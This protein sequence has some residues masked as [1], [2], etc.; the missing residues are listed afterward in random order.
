[1]SKKEQDNKQL[2]PKKGLMVRFFR[3]F[4]LALIG[5]LL[6]LVIGY[7][8]LQSVWV[9]NK[10][11]PYATQYISEELGAQ[12]HL[13]R[14]DLSL[15]D[16][17]D[18]EGLVVLDQKQDTLLAAERFKT[19]L[20]GNLL[21]LL[22][23]RLEIDQIA[24]QGVKCHV[25]RK[26]G[27]QH[28]N[29]QFLIDYFK[30][31]SKKPKKAKSPFLLSIKNL[32]LRDVAFEYLDEVNGVEV[33]SKLID[34]E[35]KLNQYDHVGSLLDI[36]YIQS[37][38]LT[39][40]LKEIEKHPLE[41][42]PIDPSTVDTSVVSSLD[43]VP[44]QFLVGELSLENNQFYY[45]H[46]R[47]QAEYDQNKPNIN[48]NHI[49][50][51]RSDIYLRKITGNSADGLKCI[52]TQI[53]V[54]ERS[55]FVISEMSADTLRLSTRQIALE[56]M[57]LITPHSHI[58]AD[59]SLRFDGFSAFNRFED[60]VSLGLKLKL[61]NNLS[62][63]DIT[64]FSSALAKNAFFTKN[65]EKLV[66]IEGN[67]KGKLNRLRGDE[68][69]I[70][71]SY[72]TKLEGSFSLINAFKGVSEMSLLVSFDQLNT[73]IQSL[74][75]LLPG[76]APPKNFDKLGNL[77]Y[78][79]NYDLIFGYD[80]ILKGKLKSDLGPA[81][82]DM[83]LD[84][85]GGRDAATY[86]G[87]LSLVNFNLQKWLDD[88]KFGK[89][90][91]RLTIQ[92]GSKGLRSETLDITLDGALEKLEYNG[93]T[94]KNA[95][96]KG[97]FAQKNFDGEIKISEKDIS[98]SF[99][100]VVNLKGDEDIY[101]F[102]AQINK[103]DLFALGFSKKPLTLK[104][105]FD[106]ISLKGSNLRNLHGEVLINS[107]QYKYADKPTQV[108]D[109]MLVVKENTPD[110][111]AYLK[112]QSPLFSSTM[113]GQF[114]LQSVHKTAVYVFH[115]NFPAFAQKLG[116]NNSDSTLRNDLIDFNL[117][118]HNTRD[119]LSIF[120]PNLDTLKNI[121]IKGR[122][123]GAQA[124]LNLD[125]NIPTIKYAGVTLNKAFVYVNTKGNQGNY[126]LMIDQTKISK[127]VELAPIR[128]AGVVDG[129]KLDFEIYNQSKNSVI[130]RVRLDGALE[131][132]DSAWQVSFD[133]SDVLLFNDQWSLSDD[134]YIRFGK[135]YFETNN[136]ELSSNDKRIIL[137]SEGRQGLALSLTN[138]D[139]NFLDNIL[140][141][142]DI[143]YS[144]R[145]YD[146]DA[147]IEN[148]F[149]MEG[150]QVFLNTDTLFI[151]DSPYG[152]ITGNFEMTSLKDAVE[153]KVNLVG[154]NHRMR[155][156]GAYIPPGGRGKEIDEIGFVR[157][158]EFQ[159]KLS[160]AQFPFEVL[161][162]F[163]PGVSKLSGNFDMD[164]QIGGKPSKVAMNGLM[165]IN[166]GAF[167]IDYLKSMFHVKKQDIRLS[168]DKIWA[169]GDTL[170]DASL[171]SYAMVSGGL[172]H[173]HFKKWRIDCGIKSI[174]NNFLILNTTEADNSDYYGQ[175][176]GRVEAQFTGPF[177]RTNIAVQAVAMKNSRLYLPLD[178][179]EDTGDITFIKFINPDE[180]KDSTKI[181]GVN[182]DF[183][184]GVQ[185]DLDLSITRD[186]LV[187]MIL[188]RRAGDNVTSQGVGDMT[189]KYD[190]TG[191]LTMYGQYEIE[192]GEYLFTLLNFFNK[193]FKVVKGG[194][195]NWYGDPYQAQINM[196]A[197][198]D[199]T[200]SVSA[201]IQEELIAQSNP[202]LESLARSPTTVKLIMNL[203]GDLFKPDIAFDMSFPNLTGEVKSLVDN[204]LRVL[205][206][207]QNELN[208]QVFGIVVVGGF[209][210][211]TAT[212]LIDNSVSTVFNS[213]TQMLLSQLSN[214][215]SS[216]A[217]DL[218]D[219]KV[220]SFDLV[221]SYDDIQVGALTNGQING[222]VKVGFLDD[223][224]NVQVGSQVGQNYNQGFYGYDAV[225]ELAISKNKQIKLKAYN[226]QEPGTISGTGQ[227]RSG[228]GIS[229]SRD[230]DSFDQ[231]F[232]DLGKRFKRKK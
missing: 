176:I 204:K 141:F 71:L 34:L 86:S 130:S 208:R 40:H 184:K 142:K 36:S 83:K 52:I 220:S 162:Q 56:G 228:L 121:S 14:I 161:S 60:E 18:F 11:I 41:K 212:G 6:M 210:P 189:I 132:K 163:V 115:Q 15:F 215:L 88:N 85:T 154:P 25:Y 107:I 93:Y 32:A 135:G 182:V 225:V 199:E 165:R 192:E 223:R 102:K 42:K 96:I 143:R 167:Q 38:G 105:N 123:D 111:N 7:L 70:G 147:R 137:N 144:G 172:R 122:V 146:F 124:L 27:E 110:G 61:G 150:I 156:V 157:P 200:A 194:T 129:Q 58:D 178:S 152:F 117:D 218:F 31:K 20:R 198:Y 177:N 108:I 229:F 145:I 91:L 3:W 118:I 230:Y 104:G 79:G 196:S 73:S 57:K 44:F 188:D 64:Y 55:G 193:P 62:F 30:P 171:T 183:L 59:F 22:L 151:R 72:D 209:L 205:R 21:S 35:V 153:W 82:L 100:G 46:F 125:I 54:L 49:G 119:I 68:L 99:A 78:S 213:V 140:K 5:L 94:Y 10:M 13:A 81:D 74:R 47:N 149:K 203:T 28:S 97:R 175:G 166:E 128:V 33:N 221:V 112:V 224:I 4:E 148:V 23:N 190:R 89:S 120:D 231:V 53:S 202:N 222:G 12:V 217:N 136:F 226:R 67:F 180:K 76:F 174:G 26:E 232:K 216:L 19:S 103:L 134:N 206:Q 139:L 2:K 65:V 195:I 98:L 116:I 75:Q 69:K 87:N 160:S 39:T 138:F 126:E 114:D 227:N 197:T 155:T 191:Q 106:H 131:V 109:S 16:A 173:D 101:Q 164:V 219:G 133:P 168:S 29:A 113:V 77:A 95:L 185:F 43:T 187:Q 45:D 24:L 127:S 66:S 92:S 51:K 201:L 1:M 9:Q 207:D 80:H 48:F 214:H 84:M 211:E 170:Y 159:S 8:A 17:V 169:D 90:D 186:A 181:K 158:D 63:K 50:V 37:V 179:Y